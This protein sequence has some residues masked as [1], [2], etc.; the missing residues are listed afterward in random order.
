MPAREIV[1]FC[2]LAWF[3]CHKGLSPFSVAL[4]WEIM[5]LD[6]RRGLLFGI[7]WVTLFSFSP[8]AVATPAGI[9]PRLY[10]E[11]LKFPTDRKIVEVD[12]VLCLR[13]F[14][15]KGQSISYFC[16]FVKYFD[17][18]FHFFRQQIALINRL[19]PMAVVDGTDN[20]S[21]DVEFIYVPLNFSIRPKILPERIGNI[22]RLPRFILI[23]IGQQCLGLYEY[24][25]LIHQFPISSGRNG[26]PAKRFVI[27]SK[28]QDHYSTKYENA[29][30]PYSL[31]LFGNYF[32]H[33]G[34]LPSYAAS[35]GCVRL[36]YDNAVFI[37]N[38]AEVGTPGEII[39]RTASKQEDI[40][41]D[42]EEADIK[43]LF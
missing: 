24:G 3:W 38:W 11:L 22:S 29:W 37:Y 30:M 41:P 21:T 33:G 14:L 17:H 25:K 19:E 2:E 34:I 13:I 16:R 15:P 5:K 20:L 26:T 9:D 1:H 39:N 12:G 40:V 4:G 8:I 32:L 36:I 10:S 6:L 42:E 23:D 35:H 7:M 27:L 18:N 43:T 31:R 28:E